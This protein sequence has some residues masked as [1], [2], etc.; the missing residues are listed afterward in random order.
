MNYYN[1][2]K[3]AINILMQSCR[4]QGQTYLIDKQILIENINNISNWPINF[5]SKKQED[6]IS[7]L[8]STQIKSQIL[9]NYKN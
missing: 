9:Q 7:K 5:K 1:F 8:L 4:F 3:L 2:Y 6:L